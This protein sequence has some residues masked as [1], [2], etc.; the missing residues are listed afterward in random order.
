MTNSL[1]DILRQREVRAMLDDAK[2]IRDWPDGREKV[3]EASR[4]AHMALFKR[5]L[6]GIS[7]EERD[8]ILEILRPCCP[9]LFAPLDPPPDRDWELPIAVE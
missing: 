8:C 3:D 6:Q 9:D 1:H 4:Q 2:L 5:A 7:D